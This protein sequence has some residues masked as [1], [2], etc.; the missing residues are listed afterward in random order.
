M[1][2]QTI[3]RYCKFTNSNKQ[4]CVGSNSEAFDQVPMLIKK[5]LGLYDYHNHY[6]NDTVY[7][8]YQ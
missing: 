7:H 4:F 3:V 2:V 5:L 8:L 6:D 1:F